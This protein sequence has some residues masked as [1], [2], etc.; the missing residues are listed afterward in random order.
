[1]REGW[2][3]IGLDVRTSRAKFSDLANQA[4]DRLAQQRGLKPHAIAADRL[5][6]W[7]DVRTYPLTQ[8]GFLWANR[9]GR[10]QIT[11]QSEKRGVFWHYAINGQAR[12]DPIPH[13][14]LYAGLVFSANGMDALDDVKKMHRLRRS[15]A[16]WRNPRWRDM[17][18]AFLW[19]LGKGTSS[20][21]LPVS[22]TQRMVLGLPPMIFQ[23][24][25]S[26][27]QAGTPPP[28]EDDPDVDIDLDDE[29]VFADEE[30]TTEDGSES[31]V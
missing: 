10:R 7:G 2:S 13:F 6:W 9:K 19:W 22:N 21:A 14:R 8:I 23:A 11:G 28:D 26:I 18:L 31:T 12:N 4:F 17:L 25:V 30:L 15:F 27:A 1:L 20:I 3:E 5:R 16:K 29:D 24:P